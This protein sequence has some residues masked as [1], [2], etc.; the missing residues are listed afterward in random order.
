[1]SAAMNIRLLIENPDQLVNHGGRTCSTCTRLKDMGSS[2]NQGPFWGS[3]NIIRHPFKEDPKRD[4]SLENY[5]E[6]GSESS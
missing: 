5:P 4:P 6:R 1:M 2:L 3:P